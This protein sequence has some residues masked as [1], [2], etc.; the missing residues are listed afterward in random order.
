M[1]IAVG[2]YVRYRNTEDPVRVSAVDR[3]GAG[4]H[5]LVLADGRRVTAWL[6]TLVPRPFNR[7]EPLV[8]RK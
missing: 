8:T 3:G 6:C 7:T 2:D 1:S 5:V 4:G